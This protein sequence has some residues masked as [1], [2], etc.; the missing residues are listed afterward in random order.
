MTSVPSCGVSQSR[1][2]PGPYDC[3]ISVAQIESI[4]QLDSVLDNIGWESMAF[5]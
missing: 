4:I 5:I 1:G 3:H 2:L